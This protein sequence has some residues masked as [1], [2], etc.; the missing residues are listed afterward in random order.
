MKYLGDDHWIG[1]PMALGI[2]SEM[3]ELLAANE[4]RRPRNM[5][6]VANTNNGK[7]TVIDRLKA[8]HPDVTD[9]DSDGVQMPVVKLNAPQSPDEDRF[10]NHILESLG[11]IYK[12][13]APKDAKFFQICRLLRDVGMKVLIFD[14]INN[15]LAGNMIQRQ[16]MFN[17]I[18]SLSNELQ[19]P[20]ILTG[21]FE[22]LV[23][24]REDKQMQNRF[25]PSILPVWE[26]DSTFLQLL[27]SFESLMPLKQRSNL[28]SEVLA[29][30][31]LAMCGGLIGELC[32]LLKR[33]GKRAI[34]SGRE[35]ISARLLLELDWVPPDQRDRQASAAEQGLS[36][37]INYKE[38]VQR[39]QADEAEAQ[40]EWDDDDAD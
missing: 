12:I 34:T 32:E 28:A 36:Y 18:K 7:T 2:L 5:L 35:R 31:L 33:A 20:I 21:T 38:M 29:P 3:A 27:A 16:Q 6:V 13:R 1:Y 37:R 11:A 30:L 22:A 40:D 26:L 8:L 24:V 25:P 9:P 14:E 19:R 10:Y 39:V 15:S 23:A 4:V 17:A